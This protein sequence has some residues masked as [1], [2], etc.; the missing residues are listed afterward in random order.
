MALSTPNLIVRSSD[1]LKSVNIW[2]IILQNAPDK[3]RDNATAALN[4]I[5]DISERMESSSFDETVLS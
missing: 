1:S 2:G 5:Y 4:R 3:N